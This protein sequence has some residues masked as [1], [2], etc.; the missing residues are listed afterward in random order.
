[1]IP[2]LTTERLVMRAPELRDFEVYAEFRASDRAKFVGGPNPRP[3][4]WQQ[5]C[6]VVGQWALR[7]Y[8]RWIVADKGNDTPY[9][10]VGLHHPEEWPEPEIAWSLFASGEGKGIAFEAA[11]AARDYA[12]Q[13]LGW[14][15]AMSLIDPQN[16]RSMA[17]GRRMGC[18]P[19][20]VF[21]HA[22]FGNMQIWRH[23]DPSEIAA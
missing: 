4:A 12:Y 6:A 20:G 17:L 15:T 1:M 19:D 16:T 9:G 11:S 10:L 22:L 21:E 14:T 2:T 8:G 5:L 13:T 18:R 23:P 3:Q 7:G